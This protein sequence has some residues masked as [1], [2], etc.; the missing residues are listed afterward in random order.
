MGI[1]TR[2][3]TSTLIFCLSARV[4]EATWCTTLGTEA[5]NHRLSCFRNDSLG[6]ELHARPDGRI[7]TFDK[8]CPLIH[9]YGRATTYRPIAKRNTHKSARSYWPA[10]M[11]ISPLCHHHNTH[12]RHKTRR[13]NKHGLLHSTY[14]RSARSVALLKTECRAEILWAP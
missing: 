6:D 11:L 3:P 13:R 9:L 10:A 5:K 7:V 8:C 2:R 12:A 14:L 1:A 4:P